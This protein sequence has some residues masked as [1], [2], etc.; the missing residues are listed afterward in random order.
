MK[1]L[2]FLTFLIV[3]LHQLEAQT[4][5]GHI[6]M[7]VNSNLS[8]SNQSVDGFENNTNNFSL[9]ATGGYFIVDNL[10]GGVSLGFSRTS[11][12]DFVSSN[13]LIGPFARYYV[14][15][16]FV[17]AQFMATSVR[18]DGFD[19]LNGTQLNLQLGY[20]AFL[21]KF[22]SIEPSLNYLKLGGD[23]NGSTTFLLNVGFAIYLPSN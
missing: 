2:L 5:K 10:V 12:G 4:E 11:A 23:F 8:F 7:G 15:N 17:G 22:V 6:L 16:V 3:S 14:E 13:F 20:A 9:N 21:N 1:K 18:S 19:T